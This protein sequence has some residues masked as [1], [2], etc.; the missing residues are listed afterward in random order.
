MLIA[1]ALLF[2]AMGA[3]EVFG[4]ALGNGW[5]LQG[6]K[7]ALIRKAIL[8]SFRRFFWYS[9]FDRQKMCVRRP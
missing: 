8:R 3:T 4:E 2:L 6:S 1:A 5:E 9:V 7:L